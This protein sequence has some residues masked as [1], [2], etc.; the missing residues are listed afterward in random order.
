L[1]NGQQKLS[2][3]IVRGGLLTFLKRHYLGVPF[4]SERGEAR[5]AARANFLDG[6]ERR[7][8]LLGQGRQLP[9]ELSFEVR[10]AALYLGGALCDLLLDG[11]GDGFHD[12]VIHSGRRGWKRGGGCVRPGDLPALGGALRQSHP[13][14]E[15]QPVAECNGKTLPKRI[16][17]SLGHKHNLQRFRGKW[18]NRLAATGRYGDPSR[19]PPGPHGPE[20]SSP[21]VSC[22]SVANFR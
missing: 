6:R 21:N 14:R 4:G 11:A 17:A 1:A 12:A 2:R 16:P 5:V 3:R 7:L 22:D 10:N 15:D 19:A 18:R 9:G 13:C 20:S 8:I